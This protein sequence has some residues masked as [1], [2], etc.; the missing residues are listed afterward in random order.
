MQT[1]DSP[2]FEVKQDSKWYKETKDRRD[3]REEFFKRV[4]ENGYFKDNGFAFYDEK[5]F[6]IYAESDDYETYKNELSK[7]PDKNGIHKFKKNTEHYKIF[8][9]M[10]SKFEPHDPFKC[11]D[12]LGFN[13]PKSSQWID[14]RWFWSVKDES[15][16]VGKEVEK[17]D[18]KNYLKVVMEHVE[19]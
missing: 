7:N 6:G 1:L 13:N 10:L 15:Q 2:V 19:D 11:H 17:I 4:K 12:V 16:V 3:G 5:H 18:Y 14:G 9:E 8:H